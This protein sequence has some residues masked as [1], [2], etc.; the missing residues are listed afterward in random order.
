MA[1]SRIQDSL[2]DCI[3]MNMIFL[4]AGM[5]A[6]LLLSS[7]QIRMHRVAYEYPRHYE[8]LWVPNNSGIREGERVLTKRLFLYE[9]DGQWYLPVTRVRYRKYAVHGNTPWHY[10][11]SSVSH[12]DK[13]LYYLPIPENIAQLLRSASK[14]AVRQGDLIPHIPRAELKTSLPARAKAYPILLPL[15]DSDTSYYD[16]GCWHWPSDPAYRPDNSG[17]V[18]AEA[19]VDVALSALWAYPAAVILYVVDVPAS[20][21]YWCSGWMR[22]G[23]YLIFCPRKLK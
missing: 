3:T 14:D 22:D 11:I 5:A 18:V 2:P 4:F 1:C 15:F 9:C 6:A 20:V 7:C 19:G 16:Y 10:H 12:D 13:S 23:F 8:G 17:G 21:V